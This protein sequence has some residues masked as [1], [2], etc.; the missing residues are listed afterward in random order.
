M[1]FVFGAVYLTFGDNWQVYAKPLWQMRSWYQETMAGGEE[2]VSAGD[3]KEEGFGSISGS[4][5]VSDS[6]SVSG[7][8][9]EWR[10]ALGGSPFFAHLRVRF[11]SADA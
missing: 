1:L 7:S 5:S 2:T 3:S 8:G 4:D 11:L 6:D 10:I 9:K